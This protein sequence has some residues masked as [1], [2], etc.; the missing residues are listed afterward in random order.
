L[1][2]KN[3]GTEHLYPSLAGLP[4]TSDEPFPE[5]RILCCEQNDTEMRVGLSLEELA[6]GINCDDKRVEIPLNSSLPYAYI[7]TL[8]C[9][10]TAYF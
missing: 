6:S 7:H 1:G 2:G 5:D 9:L 3:R 10:R 4:S 8:S